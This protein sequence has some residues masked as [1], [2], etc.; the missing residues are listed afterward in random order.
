VSWLRRSCE[1][2]VPVRDRGPEEVQRVWIWLVSGR[3]LVV[4][5][6]GREAVAL[7]VIW[8]LGVKGG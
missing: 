3:V 4:Q 7:A 1:E 2:I 5:D 8:T 6:I